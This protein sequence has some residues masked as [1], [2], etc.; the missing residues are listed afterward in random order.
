MAP[1]RALC[2]YLAA[3]EHWHHPLFKTRCQA[4]V[5]GTMTPDDVAALYVPYRSNGRAVI[6]GALEAALAG[7]L[8][9]GT[10]SLPGSSRTDIARRADELG[11][12]ALHNYD[13]RAIWVD[14]EAHQRRRF[15]KSNARHGEAA[16]AVTRSG[17]GCCV[18][19]GRQ[20]AAVG[21]QRSRKL[22][23]DE[24]GHEE[25][26]RWARRMRDVLAAAAAANALP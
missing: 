12:V 14:D 17:V 3:D 9:A 16:R 20:L 22:L 7:A 24:C 6:V 19:C 11:R 10:Y 21:R 23:C 15:V 2:H 25:E 26:A 4:L 1:L 18:C 8:E 13:G 5:R